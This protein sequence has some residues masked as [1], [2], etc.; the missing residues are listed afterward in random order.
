MVLLAYH[1]HSNP[2][3]AGTLVYNL[4]VQAPHAIGIRQQS[5]SALS[6]TIFKEQVLQE[7]SYSSVTVIIQI[8]AAAFIRGR[9][10]FE[11]G[12][13]FRPAHFFPTSL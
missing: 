8:N 6:M 3:L 13:L 10:L 11:G 7:L 2:Y 1:D 4:Y 9:R 12:T 5:R